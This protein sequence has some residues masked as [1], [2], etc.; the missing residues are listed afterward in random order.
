[1]KAEVKG[2]IKKGIAVGLIALMACINPLQTLSPANGSDTQGQ[3][4]TGQPTVASAAEKAAPYVGEVRL[5]VDKKAD[6]AKQILIDA[7]YEVIDQDLNEDAGSFWNDLGD[8][9]VY[10]GIKRTDDENKAIREMKTMNM[11]G[12]YSYS[13]LRFAIRENTYRAGQLYD[14]LRGA[15]NEYKENYEKGDYLA[16]KTH[17]LLNYIVED[18]S[19]KK[20]GD[21]LLEKIPREDLLS[22]F[23]EGNEYL[24]STITRGLILTSEQK[25]KRGDIWTERMSAVTSYNDI[26]KE[27]A[28]EKYGKTSVI[29]DEKEL[30]TRMIESDLNESATQILDKWDEIRNIFLNEDEMTERLE[31]AGEDGVEDEEIAELGEDIQ[32]VA[33]VDYTKTVKY[34]KKTL[35]SFFTLPK[36]AFEKDITRLYPMVYALSDAQRALIPYM[37]YSM[38]L[39]SALTRMGLREEKKNVEAQMDSFL[40]DAVIQLSEVSLY[41]GV[42]RAMYGDHAAATSE[43]TAN[44]QASSADASRF[45]WAKTRMYG[46]LLVAGAFLAVGIVGVAACVYYALTD[47]P[48]K[49][50]IY[51]AWDYF[52]KLLDWHAGSYG[53]AIFGMGFG[54]IFAGIAIATWFAYKNTTHNTTQLSIPEVMVDFDVENDAGKYVTYHVAKWNKDRGD[55]GDRADRGDLNG[56]AAKEWL[57]LYTTTD[58]TMGAPILADSIVTIV[59]SS[60][61]PDAGGD[62]TYRPLTMFGRKSVQNL[63]DE[64]YS[65]NDGV[66][67]IYLWYKK[68]VDVDKTDVIIDDT[69]ED[70][71]DEKTEA[72]SEEATA[73]PDAMPETT[74][75]NIGGSSTVFIGLGCG[76][77]GIIVGIFIGFFIRRKKQVVD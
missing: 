6:K 31:E 52:G 33:I 68:A 69:D 32:N 38:L 5:A 51:D 24:V 34:G 35:Y 26:V 15:I 19:G 56:E 39:Q 14:R 3:D 57:A 12:K 42:D 22:M 55:N 54:L 70:D 62:G 53:M 44:R 43:A 64:A 67:G 20:V 21:L 37:D 48:G 58:K 2:I 60:S 75:S 40:K 76:V 7:G 17:D 73:A 28:R 50:G 77:V 29:G 36:S 61:M 45:D 30:V 72:T 25:S 8:Q 66:D 13:D 71:Q 47:L 65:Y 27:Y 9:A 49:A 16:I 74:G 11:L 18:D 23:V 10:M 41:E 59:G 1:M 63:V 46:F 4:L